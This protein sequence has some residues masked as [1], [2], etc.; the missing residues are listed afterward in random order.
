MCVYA[1]LCALIEINTLATRNQQGDMGHTTKQ[2]VVVVEVAVVV[3]MVMVV[4]VMVMVVV[5]KVVMVVVV[6]TH[7]AVI[8]VVWWC[9]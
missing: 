5:V 1:C 9:W 7:L 6:S 3:M 8:A 2:V 4:M